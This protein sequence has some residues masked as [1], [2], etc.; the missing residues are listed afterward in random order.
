M[1]TE[2]IGIVHR[3][4]LIG[5][6]WA[7]QSWQVGVHWQSN[8]LMWGQSV[9]ETKIYSVQ[10]HS[11]EYT[12]WIV[13]SNFDLPSKI[14]NWKCSHS[15]LFRPSNRAWRNLLKRWMRKDYIRQES[16]KICVWTAM[17]TWKARST[18]TSASFPAMG[19]KLH[20]IQVLVPQTPDFFKLVERKIRERFFAKICFPF[21]WSTLYLWNLS[22]LKDS[23]DALVHEDGFA[24]TRLVSVADND[25]SSSNDD[26][27]GTLN[28]ANT[29]CQSMFALVW[30][31]TSDFP[32]FRHFQANFCEGKEL[33]T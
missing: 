26:R 1:V 20:R 3:V 7:W 23:I 18:E 2:H 4:A 28:W 22:R 6:W 13:S 10:I 8:P 21:L 11:C 30:V 19:E 5:G 16:Q 27:K 14:F 15:P 24:A 12:K 9:V 25:V 33:P 29:F 17:F 32:E 31:L